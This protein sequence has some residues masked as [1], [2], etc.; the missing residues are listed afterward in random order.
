[1]DAAVLELLSK[2]SGD[3]DQPLQSSSPRRAH[4]PLEG[5]KQDAEQDVGHFGTAP[6]VLVRSDSDSSE[7]SFHVAEDDVPVYKGQRPIAAFSRS[8]T[9]QRQPSHPIN[10]V[11]LLLP[12]VPTIVATGR[13]SSPR[14][15]TKHQRQISDTIEGSVNLQKRAAKT[16][17]PGRQQ[18]SGRD[19]APTSFAHLRFAPKGQ[20]R[21]TRSLIFVFGGFDVTSVFRSPVHV[22]EMVT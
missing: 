17:S 16:V 13:G 4:Q 14:T 8:P 11:P 9:R 2:L 19:T 20:E 15:S 7:R 5:K 22:Q 18:V 10:T 6:M 21:S 12:S 3:E 1:M